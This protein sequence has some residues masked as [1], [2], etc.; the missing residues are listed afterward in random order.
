M[1][2]I[3]YKLD[4]TSATRKEQYKTM[5]EALA[6]AMEMLQDGYIVQV[7]EE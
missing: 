1:V 7:Y 5:D 3:E 4:N 6:M 2:T